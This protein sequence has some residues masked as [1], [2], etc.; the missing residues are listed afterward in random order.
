VKLVDKREETERVRFESLNLGDVFQYAKDS[1]YIV[2]TAYDDVNTIN[3]R[4]FRP[5]CFR[6]DH[7]VKPVNAQ[8]LLLPSYQE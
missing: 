2:V 3:L 6:P 5:H 8:L 4:T 7:M 1:L